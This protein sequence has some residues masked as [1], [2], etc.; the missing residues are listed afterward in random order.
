MEDKELIKKRLCEL[1]H[2]AYERN[3][4]TYSD[5]L[6]YDDI[7]TLYEIKCDT[8]FVLYGGYENAERCIACFGDDIQYYP[9]KCIKS[10]PVQQKFADKLS[11]RDFLGSLMNLGIERDTIGDIV[12][13]DNCGYI[14]CTEKIADYIV[15][16]LKR[17]KH[18]VIKNTIIDEIPEFLNKLPD[19]E[20]M[21]VSSIRVDTVTSSVFNLSR[22]TVSQLVN[23]QMIFINSRT[24]YKDSILLKENDKVT[25]RGYG[26]YIFC[27][28]IN[29]TKKHKKLIS[30]RIYK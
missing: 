7:S 3:Y 11:H 22:N 5:F 17:V 27:N 23:R 18:T 14:F 10:Q 28:V 6:S 20:N 2:R 16:E 13:E 29:E 1:S 4:N 30:V 26:K 15:N 19:E 25:V 8:P 12:I 24:I 21:T 9:I